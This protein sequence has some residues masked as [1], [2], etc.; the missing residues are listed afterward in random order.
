MVNSKPTVIRM[1]REILGLKPGDGLV[2]DHINQNTLDNRRQNLR[3]SNKQL[4]GMNRPGNNPRSGFKGVTFSYGK[5]NASISIKGKRL[6]LGYF[7]DKVEAA[8]FYDK[9]A[10]ELFGE[11]AYLNFGEK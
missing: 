2:A 6:N 1:H 4:N 9:K 11:H 8:K 3:I 7:K 10:K 5:W